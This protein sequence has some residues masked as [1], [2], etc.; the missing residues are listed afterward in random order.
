VAEEARLESVYT[1]KA[2]PEFE[3]RSL[4]SNTKC[5]VSTDTPHFL[6]GWRELDLVNAR[7]CHRPT[8]ASPLRKI[9]L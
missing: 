7:T 9:P 2:Y 4:R 5:G 3:S 6:S 8:T 1:P